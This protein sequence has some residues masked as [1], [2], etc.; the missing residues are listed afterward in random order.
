MGLRKFADRE[1]TW[2]IEEAKVWQMP[3]GWQV[4]IRAERCDETNGRPVGLSYGLILQ[5]QSG[6]RLLGFDNSHGFDGAADDDPFDHEH[7]YG[8]VG[9]RYQYH[10]ESPARLF[11]D[12]FDRVESACRVCDVKFEFEDE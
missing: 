1:I 3:N 10:F 4:V 7:R 5:D 2:L 12:F 6:E 8:L 9:R 11:E